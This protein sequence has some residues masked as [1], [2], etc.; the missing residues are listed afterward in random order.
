MD[1]DYVAWMEIFGPG[2]PRYQAGGGD[3]ND[4]YRGM[5]EGV[6]RTQVL[7]N[8]RADPGLYSSNQALADY[9]RQYADDGA[10]PGRNVS[11]N[12]ALGIQDSTRRQSMAMG[13]EGGSNGQG[14][15]GGGDCG[16]SGK[17]DGFCTPGNSRTTVLYPATRVPKIFQMTHQRV[18]GYHNCYWQSTLAAQFTRK[19]SANAFCRAWNEMIKHLGSA[20]AFDIPTLTAI[21]NAVIDGGS[22]AWGLQN[23]F[24]PPMHGTGGTLPPQ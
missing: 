21:F 5:S 18:K 12:R 17:S 9:Y 13:I 11:V 10:R 3:I 4:V 24:D 23:G 22:G 8:L 16:C 19:S 7:E 6:A 20:S 1:P 2:G 15:T 14:N